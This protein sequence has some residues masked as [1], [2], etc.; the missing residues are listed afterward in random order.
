MTIGPEEVQK[1]YKPL[2]RW[3]HK[4]SDLSTTQK[5]EARGFLLGY[6]GQTKCF[7]TGKPIVPLMLHDAYD[8]HHLIPRGSPGCN[9]MPN[10]RLTLHSANAAKGKPR[11]SRNE[12]ETK[13]LDATAQLRE[14]VDY[15]TGSAEMQAN[16][17]TEVP[18]R[19]WLWAKMRLQKRVLWH[20][21]VY[22]G[23][24]AVGCSP[25]ASRDY[26]SKMASS[27]GPFK[28]A[29]KGRRKYLVPKDWTAL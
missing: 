20:D 7:L 13:L 6:F 5:R 1:Q 26:A 4:V 18:Y 27:E 23:A 28:P 19:N 14:V 24:E 15:S 10:L 12:T 29:G 21:A 11:V 9:L 8:L 22:G 17:E 25:Q 16:N 3:E 2:R